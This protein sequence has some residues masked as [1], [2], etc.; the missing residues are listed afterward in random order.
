MSAAFR[1][2]A[3]PRIPTTLDGAAAAAQLKP[4]AP[5]KLC[6]QDGVFVSVSFLL[7]QCHKILPSSNKSSVGTV[8]STPGE[9]LRSGAMA[10]VPR[11]APGE[12][13]VPCV[14]NAETP[15]GG[16]RK[17]DEKGSQVLTWEL[18]RILDNL[19]KPAESP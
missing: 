8:M 7:L 9:S 6:L 19:L 16:S 1:T 12:D 14:Q 3:H 15:T 18:F 4:N 13:P 2:E 11:G 10:K 17:R 5:L